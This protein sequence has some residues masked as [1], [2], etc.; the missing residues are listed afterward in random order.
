MPDGPPAPSAPPPPGAYAYYP[1]PIPSAASE[2]L[3]YIWLARMAALTAAFVQLG[4]IVVP[5]NILAFIGNP[6]VIETTA[7]AMSTVVTLLILP[8]LRAAKR[9]RINNGLP[10]A[11]ILD[12]KGNLQ[13]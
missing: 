5:D 6:A 7:Y 10:C 4:V 12:K 3:W 1:A 2:N 11:P 13:K 8:I 9:A